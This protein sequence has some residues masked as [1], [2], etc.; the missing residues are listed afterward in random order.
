[1]QK[2]DL[3][4][5]HSRD[6]NLLSTIVIMFLIGGLELFFADMNGFPFKMVFATAEDTD[7]VIL[8]VILLALLM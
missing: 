4:V 8:V 5:G 1:M 3:K 7:T 2:A 6:I